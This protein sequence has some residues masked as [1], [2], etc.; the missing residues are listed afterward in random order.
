MLHPFDDRAGSTNFITENIPT[1][2]EV[3]AN[4]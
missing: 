2:T 3:K 1:G 4:V